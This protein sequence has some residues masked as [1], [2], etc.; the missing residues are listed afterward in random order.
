MK[1]GAK[2]DKT[3]KFRYVLWRE[4]D[5]GE[6]TCV[7]VMLNPS[8]ADAKKDDQTIKKCIG[9]AQRWGYRRLEVVN[10]FAYRATDP[11]KLLKCKDPVG[12]DNDL[13]LGAVLFKAKRVVIAW[14]STKVPKADRVAEVLRIVANW[15]ISEFGALGRTKDGEPRHPGRNLPYNT[16]FEQIDAASELP[17]IEEPCA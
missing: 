11:K 10:L 1:R 7:F 8:T 16:S 13:Y 17:Q 2:L 4:W 15:G 14:G 5:E 9:F 6:G 3:R 12:P